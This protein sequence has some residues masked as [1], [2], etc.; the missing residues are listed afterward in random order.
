MPST[1]LRQHHA[2]VHQTLTH[3]RALFSAAKEDEVPSLAVL[4]PRAADHLQTEDH[5]DLNPA[6][7]ARVVAEAAGQLLACAHTSLLPADPN[8]QCYLEALDRLPRA[9]RTGLLT[10]AV[11][12]TAP[13]PDDARP[14]TPRI[15]APSG[16]SPVRRRTP[17]PC[18]CACNSGG[19]CGG[20]GHAGCGGRR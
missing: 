5:L 9:A 8:L 17:G 18:P 14:P 15:L 6:A 4:L 16:P 10:G 1:S 11:R 3:A 12:R 20:C 2:L 19:F 13:H 7:L